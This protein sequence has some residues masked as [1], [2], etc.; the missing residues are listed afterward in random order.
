[1]QTE[2]PP[3]LHRLT[4][5]Q[6]AAALPD[7]NV[8]LSA[9]AGSGKTQVLSSRVIRLLLEPGIRPENL[10]CLTFTKAAAAEMAE[11]INRRLA[12]W[13]QAKGSDLARDLDSIGAD[14]GPETQ[15]AAR[16]LFAQVL[17]A[18][19]GGLQI[20]TIH[21]FCQSL[22]AS[23]PEEAGLLPGFE[24]IDDR[25]IAQLHSDALS[26]LVENAERDGRGWLITDLQAMSLAQSEDGV[27]SYLRRCAA[28]GEALET[29][30]PDHQGAEVLA[31]RIVGLDFEGSVA[32]EMARRC[33]DAVIDWHMVEALAEMN[34]HWRTAT[35]DKRAE[36]IR[37]WLTMPPGER[38]QHLD[39]LTSCW[40]NKKGD[41]GKTGPKKEEGYERLALE[42]HLWTRELIQFRNA[43]AYSERL[44]PALI[45]GK[46]Y[47][48]R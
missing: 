42:A 13:V 23:F 48:A 7:R 18:P 34:H 35:G 25:A 24:P 1:M 11:R 16:K 29:L 41:L 39:E 31:R 38:A 6:K 17:D 37:R 44:A 8:W 12:S 45:A 43:A 15:T 28:Q 47:A 26:E 9:S 3:M 46:A 33:D 36:I 4:E 22:L 30:V 5:A 40:T 19:G 27:R 21:S 14:I 32:D 20:M 2:G 10:L